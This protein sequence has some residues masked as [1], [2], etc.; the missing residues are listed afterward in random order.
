MQIPQ[1][2]M[3]STSAKIE[4][5]STPAQQTIQQPKAVQHIEQPQAEMSI[6]TIPGQLSID[7]TAAWESMD[8][9]H[10]FRRIE[11]SA[12]RGYSA[13][14]S[15]MARTA[16]EGDEL[17]AIENGGSAIA[18]QAS[19]NSALMNYDYNIGFVPP[20]FSVKI[21]YMPGKASIYAQAKQPIIQTEVQKPIIDYRAGEVRTNL[22]QQASLQ[23]D[24]IN[25]EI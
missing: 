17:M 3:Q 10:I 16:S 14:L 11:E 8:I 25:T 19:R 4:I 20:P 5:S 24:V 6:E 21:N 13:V 15:G 22:R 7:Q 1:I 2:R 23:M 18:S 9:K 12:Q